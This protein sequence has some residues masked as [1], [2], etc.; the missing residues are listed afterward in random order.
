[1]LERAEPTDKP[2]RLKDD[3]VCDFELYK[4]GSIYNVRV[5]E[6]AKTIG[7]PKYLITVEKFNDPED[8]DYLTVLK[9]NLPADNIE[10]YL[11][12][13]LKIYRDERTNKIA[14]IAFSTVNPELA[15][16]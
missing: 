7:T 2:I 15:A 9:A 11:E 6:M 1:M 12:K 13:S 4:F 8:Q 3:S 14:Y 16:I 5:V 10:T